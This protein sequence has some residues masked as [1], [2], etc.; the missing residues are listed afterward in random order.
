[1]NWSKKC[2]IPCDGMQKP[3]EA[4]SICASCAAPHPCMFHDGYYNNPTL[5]ALKGGAARRSVLR[6]ST[7]C[8]RPAGRRP[9]S[10]AVFRRLAN[11][12]AGRTKSVG[13]TGCPVPPHKLSSAMRASETRTASDTRYCFGAFSFRIAFA[14]VTAA[15][16]SFL[17]SAFGSLMTLLMT[18]V[19]IAARTGS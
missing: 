8:R 7:P 4:G 1:M 9:A 12:H 14:L 2:N 19:S 13:A 5:V 17:T 11:A 18:S 16:S 6:G 3:S 10:A 15:S